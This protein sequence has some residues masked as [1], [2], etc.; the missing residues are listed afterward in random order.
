MMMTLLMTR[1]CRAAKVVSSVG[2]CLES[3]QPFPPTPN[4]R[5]LLPEAGLEQDARKRSVVS[6]DSV[7]A[8]ISAENSS[9][10]HPTSSPA[11]RLLANTWWEREGA[12]PDS[13]PPVQSPGGRV[14]ANGRDASDL[15][16]AGPKRRAAAS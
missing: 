4:P 7:R 10:H 8:Q 12:E 13:G 2:H 1:C 9:Q 15:W 14:Q 5:Q 6:R 16:E 3:Q 11:A